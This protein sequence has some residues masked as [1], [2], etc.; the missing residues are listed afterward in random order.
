MWSSSLLHLHSHLLLSTSLP[1]RTPRMWGC[2]WSISQWP[3]LSC[4]FPIFIQQPAMAIWR[5]CAVIAWPASPWDLGLPSSQACLLLFV[6][7]SLA[8][9]TCSRASELLASG[10]PKTF[11]MQSVC[12]CSTLLIPFCPQ[13]LFL[14]PLK[15]CSFWVSFRF[16]LPLS[17][18]DLLVNSDSRRT[19]MMFGFLK[20][21]T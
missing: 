5:R 12:P 21:L 14:V 16:Y 17:N 19:G 8:I 6:I 2:I 20:H 7:C 9:Q 1:V 10:C 11:A 13:V 4:S 18:L 3:L 15:Q